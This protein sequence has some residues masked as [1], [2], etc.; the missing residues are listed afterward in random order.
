MAVTKEELDRIIALYN[1]GKPT[2]YTDSEYDALLEEYLKEHGGESARPFNRQQQSDGVN[3]IVSTLPKVY[4]ITSS[5]REGQKTYEQWIEKHPSVQDIILQPKFDGCSVAVDFTSGKFFTRGDYDDGKSVD[6]TDIF[7]D[8][9]DIVK[10]YAAPSTQAMKFEAIL[11]HENYTQYAI[12][13]TYKRPRDFVAA[14][15]T[16]RDV[17]NAKLITL[18]PL[19]GYTMDHRQYIPRALFEQSTCLF[20]MPVD[21]SGMESF[22]KQRLDDDATIQFNG[23]T[24]S[25]DGVVASSFYDMD[26]M[27][28]TKPDDEVAIKILY[29]VK[30]TKLITVD[31]QF[32]KQGRITPVAILEP[33]KFDTVTV[34]HVT[35]STLDRVLELKLRHNDTVHVMYNIVPYLIDSEHDGD[36]PIQ[37]PKK[38]PIC[39]ADLEYTTLKQVRC[40]NPYCEGLKLG[41]IIRHAEKMKM[42]GVSRG[43][44]TKLYDAGMCKNI[45]DLYHLRDWD[46]DGGLRTLDGFGDKSVWNLLTTIDGA[47]HNATLPRFLGALPIADTSEETWKMVL[48]VV[49]EHVIIHSMIDGTFPDQIMNVGYI[50][51]VGEMKLKRIISGYLQH[52]DEIAT[53][54][55][56]VPNQLRPTNEIKSQFGKLGMTGTRDPDLTRELTESGYEVGSFTN[57]C[58]GLI[59]PFEGFTSAKTEKAERLHIPIYTIQRA[60]EYLVKPF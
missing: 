22:I 46:T 21:Y 2:G 58:I 4:G 30:S 9:L 17:E 44:L 14:T 8:H 48:K 13:Q 29:N 7:K 56:W 35:L 53:L 33:V 16:S 51:N 31:Y 39:N 36:Y 6:V 5:M 26:G 34:D 25:I 49:P 54:M 37:I 32:G 50:P 10:E 42:V 1:Q 38:C 11:C 15:I 52:K 40:S 28:Y 47:V 27:I 41:A 3:A 20:T 19:R 45:S 24:Y 55:K 23:L 59:I 43:I 18:V 12:D 57:D 60:R